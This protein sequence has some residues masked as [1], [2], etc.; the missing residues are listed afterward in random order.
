VIPL[1]VLAL[2]SLFVGWI[3]VPEAIG[4]GNR[5]SQFLSPLFHLSSIEANAVSSKSQPLFMLISLLV[6]AL[7]VGAAW[8][9]YG[10]RHTLNVKVGSLVPKGK[11]LFENKYYV[12][13]IYELTVV[14]W[15]KGFARSVSSRLFEDLLVNRSVETLVKFVRGAAKIL[16][17][18]QT[19]S[20]RAYLVYV[21]LGAV[22]L[23]YW[24]LR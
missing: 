10:L 14:R 22:A 16:T 5:L 13:E 2:G 20:V 19:G 1:L 18:T 11:K 4:G 6:A 17:R 15:V 23:V 9:V 24:I 12:D 3:G 21:L 8:Y 7:G